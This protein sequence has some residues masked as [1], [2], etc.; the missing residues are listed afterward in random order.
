MLTTILPRHHRILYI[1]PIS[2][3]IVIIL[4]NTFFKQD[5]QKIDESNRKLLTVTSTFTYYKPL[6]WVWYYISLTCCI[7]Y[8]GLSPTYY[9][10]YFTSKFYLKTL[11]H[12]DKENP[13]STVN[14]NK[15]SKS[16][17]SLTSLICRRQL[18]LRILTVCSVLWCMSL[19]VVI[20]L[21]KGRFPAKDANIQPY[22]WY[23]HYSS[24]LVLLISHF[25]YMASFLY[26]LKISNPENKKIHDY[27][28]KLIIFIIYDFSIFMMCFLV[29]LGNL[30]FPNFLEK[31][32]DATC[33]FEYLT[34]L[35]IMVWNIEIW[36]G[37]TYESRSNRYQLVLVKVEDFSVKEKIQENKANKSNQ[38]NSRSSS[39]T[40]DTSSDETNLSS[41]ESTLLELPPVRQTKTLSRSLS[42]L[43]RTVSAPFSGMI[44]KS[45][46]YSRVES[47]ELV[48]DRDRCDN[49][50][51]LED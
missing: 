28:T 1:V 43:T 39:L 34:V 49:E 47:E 17:C 5:L 33:F 35:C 37:F 38:P 24:L 32:W 7:L 29:T 31:F 40:D 50:F 26:L 12:V 15:K 23:I 46:G 3:L 11:H 4:A 21:I 14:G 16:K 18:A 36:R 20:F 9:K 45:A 13:K 22:I 2:Y 19:S 25:L 42:K 10:A 44:E 8:G 27:A 51:S 6:R 30:F 41:P 48:G